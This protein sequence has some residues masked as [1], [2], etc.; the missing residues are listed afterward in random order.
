MARW[1]LPEAATV[2]TASRVWAHPRVRGQDPTVDLLG[3]SRRASAP[4]WVLPVREVRAS[5]GAGSVYLTAAI[6]PF[7]IASATLGNAVVLIRDSDDR[8]AYP[9]THVTVVA[10]SALLW[11]GWLWAQAE[12]RTLR[13]SPGWRLRWGSRWW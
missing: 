6:D 10:G 2:G 12:A 9:A 5:V 11:G 3:P 1:P 7:V 8:R 4:D 13:S